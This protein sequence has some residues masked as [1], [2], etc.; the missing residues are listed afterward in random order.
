[1]KV[2]KQLERLLVVALVAASPA[3][4]NAQSAGTIVDVGPG[5][6][7]ASGTASGPWQLVDSSSSV[8]NGTSLGKALAVGAGPNGLAIS[9]SVGVNR[10]GVG[11]A[12]NFNLA[13]GAQGTHVSHGGVISQGGNSR[14]IAGGSSQTGWQGPQGGSQVTGFGNNTRAYSKSRTT[15]RS[16]NFGGPAPSG[17]RFRGR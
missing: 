15:F 11:A 3:L 10:G 6:A 17:F 1:M 14:V 12:H 5:H 2:H 4:A 13:I 9:H 8:N 16:S 7:G